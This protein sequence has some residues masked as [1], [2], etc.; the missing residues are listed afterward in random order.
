[1][2]FIISENLYSS[3]VEVFLDNKFHVT[4]VD[5]WKWKACQWCDEGWLQ[6][7]GY[8]DQMD[9]VFAAV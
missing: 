6:L 8:T 5:W 4:E 7:M 2:K 1:M 3:T 9:P